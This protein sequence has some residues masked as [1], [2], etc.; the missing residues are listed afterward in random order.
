MKQ[1]TYIFLSIILVVTS[2]I[3]TFAQDAQT[4]LSKMDEVM[5]SPKDKQG[6]VQIILTNRQGKEKEREAIFK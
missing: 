4:L 3:D 1:F 5:Y 2:G 6:T